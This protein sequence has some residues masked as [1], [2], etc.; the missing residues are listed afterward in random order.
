MQH[1]DRDKYDL[2]TLSDIA[3][4]GAPRPVAHVK[5]LE[6]AFTDARPALG[7]GLTETNA[8]GCGNFWSNYHEKPASTGRAQKPIVELAI[9]GSGD[10]NLPTG[11]TGEI[12]PSHR[13]S[14]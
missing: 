14:S 7:Y 9:L 1:P 6:D 3:A 11:E 8:V 10:A 12:A 2:S 4:G 13:R 5:R